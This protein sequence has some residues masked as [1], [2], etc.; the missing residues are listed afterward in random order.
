MEYNLLEK[1][2]LWIDRIEMQSVN[3]TDVAAAVA[4]VLHLDPSE[5]LVVDVRETHLTLDILRRTIRAEDLVGKR[6]ALLQRLAQIPGLTLTDETEVHSDGILGMI[7]VPPEEAGEILRAT[8]ALGEQI[9]Q[10]VA[11]RALLFSS[12]FEVKRSMIADTNSPFLKAELEALGFAVTIG[13]VLD[14]DEATIAHAL[15]S[16]VE[17]GYG[18]VITT[19]GVGAEDKDRTVEALLKVDPEAATPYLVRYE[20]GKGRHQKDGVRIGVG[21]AGLTTIVNL[22]GPNDEVQVG[23]QVLKQ[24]LA[25]GSLEKR[26]LA[27]AIAGALRQILTRKMEAWSHKHHGHHGH[28]HHKQSGSESHEP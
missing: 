7:A 27:D 1:T 11:R 8:E 18:L 9:R 14:D 12:G 16:G 21:Q 17:A 20:A 22:P 19:G 3:L 4:E 26:A 6:E 23:L 24:H 5:V 13:P 15:R 25:A 28:H 2:E 10:A